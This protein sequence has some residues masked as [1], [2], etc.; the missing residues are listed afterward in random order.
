MSDVV[1]VIPLRGE[2]YDDWLM[3]FIECEA[4][5]L[6]AQRAAAAHAL[7][8]RAEADRKFSAMSAFDSYRTRVSDAAKRQKSL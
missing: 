2:R 5:Q 3:R 8:E 6:F 1:E 4:R 7:R